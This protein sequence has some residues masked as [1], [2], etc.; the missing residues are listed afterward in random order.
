[1]NAPQ[2]LIDESLALENAGGSADLA[3]ELYQMLQ[4]ELPYYQSKLQDNYQNQDY[5][6]LY[7]CVH[8][9]N[10]SATYCGVP[11]LKQAVNTFEIH[12]KRQQQEFYQEDLLCLQEQIRLLLE[13]PSFMS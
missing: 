6:A 3:K 1:M 10:G 12:L 7:Q 8:K 11:A 13:L 9:L 2:P 5:A 4:N